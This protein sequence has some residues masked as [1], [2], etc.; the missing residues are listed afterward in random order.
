MNEM[1]DDDLDPV[2]TM[3]QIVQTTGADELLDAISDALRAE[4]LTVNEPLSSKQFSASSICS[5]AAAQVRENWARID[6]RQP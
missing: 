1:H 6:R 5:K 2:V 4:A 3:R